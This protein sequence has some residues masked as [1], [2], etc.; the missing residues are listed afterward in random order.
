M[1]SHT[2]IILGFVVGIIIVLTNAGKPPPSAFQLKTANQQKYFKELIN[3]DTTITIGTGP[4]GC[5]KTYLACHAALQTLKKKECSKI[6]LT[7]PT[8]SVDDEQMGFLPGAIQQKMDPWTRP[9]FDIM[10]E[11]FN[12]VQI[13][14]MIN[15]EIIEISP[16]AYMRGRTFKDAY[17]VADEMQNSSP[18]QMLMLMTRVGENTK[19]AITGDLMQ[20]DRIQ[21]SNQPTQKNG[22]QDLIERLNRTYHNHNHNHNHNHDHA[23]KHIQLDTEDIQRSNIIA[24]I[25]YIYK[26]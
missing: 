2:R 19:M 15:N 1:N 23:I 13:Q 25:L 24:K 3:P 12:P 14:T 7:R 22:L 11:M 21:T 5:G 8:I 6:I 20:S 9:L 17:I 26:I 10:K 16:L 4:A 18:N